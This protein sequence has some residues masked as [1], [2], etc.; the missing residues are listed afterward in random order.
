MK[1]YQKHES[2]GMVRFSRITSSGQKN[3]F[4][5]SI[6][7]SNTITLTIGRGEVKRD[8]NREWFFSH[9]DIVEVEM[10][11]NQFAELITTLNAGS[12]IP[13]TIR[14]LEGKGIEDPPYE[15]KRQLFENEFRDDVKKI[16]ANLNTLAVELQQLLDEKAPTRVF[17]EFV[18]KVKMVAQDVCANLPFVQKSFNE[19]I[20]K[21]VT[22]AKS[23]IEAFVMNKVTSLGI[24][25]LKMKVPM[26]E[27]DSEGKIV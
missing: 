3:L 9:E 27:N 16:G 7:H 6:T 11:E 4:G 26:I 24:E 20:D 13:C 14:R 22:E 8:L 5:S 1:E 17:R 12:G 15:N 23:D 2:Y 10:S 19:A 18:N 25:A 21:T